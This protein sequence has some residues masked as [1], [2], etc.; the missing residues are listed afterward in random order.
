MLGLL[1]AIA[2]GSLG[3][4]GPQPSVSAVTVASSA[5]GGCSRPSGGTLTSSAAIVVSWTV[6]NAQSSN[7]VTNIYENGVL[8]VSLANTVT[9]WTKNLTGLVLN[10][11][12][13]SFQSNW[14]YTVKVVR[15]SDSAVVSQAVSSE[16]Q[17][18]YGS[19]S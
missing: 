2:S 16:W 13:N 8:M 5:P 11:P 14:V 17:Q 15:N 19:C 12:T 1:L 9:S 10:G 7:Y 3:A 18:R 6:A 4:I